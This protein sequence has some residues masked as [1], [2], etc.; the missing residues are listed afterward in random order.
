MGIGFHLGS[1]ATLPAGDLTHAD[2]PP[3]IQ[4]RMFGGSLQMDGQVILSSG[5]FDVG[6]SLSG[7]QVPTMLASFGHV[8]NELTGS[9]SGQIVLQGKLGTTDVLKGNGAARISDANVYKL[10][11]IVQLLNLLRITPTEDVAFTDGAVEF[12][13]FGDETNFTDLR[14][15]GDLVALKGGGT[16][17]RKRELDLTFNTQVSPQNTFTRLVLPLRNQRYTLLTI[18]VHGPVHSPEIERR[19]LDGVGETLGWLLPRI[20]QRGTQDDSPEDSGE[21]QVAERFRRLR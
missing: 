13:I 1:Q 8:D 3:P 21:E 20:R 2:K 14:L 4:G 5:N 19:A 7:A 16:L 11:L 6:M 17:N 15:W 9:C 18:D 12:T 10:P